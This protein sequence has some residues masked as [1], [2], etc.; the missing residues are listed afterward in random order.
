MDDNMGLGTPNF[1]NSAW[2]PEQSDYSFTQG[3]QSNMGSY[4]NYAPPFQQGQAENNPLDYFSTQQE[5]FASQQQAFSNTFQSAG[6][7][8][9]DDLDKILAS[10]DSPA[11]RAGSVLN[12]LRQSTQM[13]GIAPYGTPSVFGA[14]D[15]G[16][17]PTSAWKS[18]LRRSA[19]PA[20]LKTDMANPNMRTSMRYGQITPVDSPPEDSLSTT[21]KDSK[22]PS[23]KHKLDET[24]LPEAPPKVKK[25]RKSKKKPLTKEQEEAKR[26][27]FLE[28]NRVAA[29]KCRQNRKKWIDDLQTKAHM[30][31]HD[32]AEKKATIQQLEEELAMLKSTAFIHSRECNKHGMTAWVDHEASRIQHLGGAHA[33]T[34]RQS[35]DVMSHYSHGSQDSPSS[36]SRP[37][38]SRGY[39]SVSDALSRRYSEVTVAD[40]LASMASPGSA[41]SSAPSSRRPSFAQ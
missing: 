11:T 17:I 13:Q 36:T 24:T 33:Q 26:K 16:N 21:Q 20:R 27:K 34:K 37:Q 41:E 8:P 15:A 30:L 19:S 3:Y 6:L 9:N 40:D 7:Q 18:T 35:D 12:P 14:S 1:F 4:S 28:R 29:D 22:T 2:D 39:G 23:L 25:P 5:H 38:S 10:S 31:S 32:N